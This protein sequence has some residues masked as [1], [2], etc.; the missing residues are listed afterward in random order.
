MES[1]DF[2]FSF[3]VKMMLVTMMFRNLTVFHR[4]EL[5]SLA[6]FLMMMMVMFVANGTFVSSIL[7]VMVMNVRLWSIL[8]QRQTQ[9]LTKR[10]GYRDGC[11][12]GL[13]VQRLRLSSTGAGAS[14][15]STISDLEL[16]RESFEL[17]YRRSL[18][19]ESRRGLFRRYQYDTK[20]TGVSLDYKQ[21]SFSVI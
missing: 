16:S 19:V 3:A 15:A 7:F 6:L 18:T 17:R 13:G 5:V 2:S 1:E 4:L 11:T 14:R 8:D 20:R 12:P 21:L 9:S 10:V